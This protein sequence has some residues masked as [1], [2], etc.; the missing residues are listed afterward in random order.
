MD[1]CVESKSAFISDTP[2]QDVQVLDNLFI[3]LITFF[4]MD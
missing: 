1:V 3:Q 4:G 2:T